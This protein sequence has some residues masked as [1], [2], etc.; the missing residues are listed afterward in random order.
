MTSR[1]CFLHHPSD[2]TLHF[3][4]PSKLLFFINIC[5]Y[6]LCW[7]SITTAATPPWE[8]WAEGRLSTSPT[9]DASECKK[10]ASGLTLGVESAWVLKI[11]MSREYKAILGEALLCLS[12]VTVSPVALQRSFVQMMFLIKNEEYFQERDN[13]PRDNACPGILP[14]AHQVQG[15]ISSPKDELPGCRR[16]GKKGT[17]LMWEC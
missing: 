10:S 14:W 15:I 17:G 11:K 13:R 2:N 6:Y 4:A 12:V 7:G 16:D 3:H 5:I 9:L 8:G 1:D